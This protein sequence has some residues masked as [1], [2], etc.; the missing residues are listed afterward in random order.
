MEKK[1]SGNKTFGKGGV[2]D[3][4]VGALKRG[5]GRGGCDPLNNS[6]LLLGCPDS[7]TIDYIKLSQHDL[8]VSC[9]SLFLL[10][11]LLVLLIVLDQL[12]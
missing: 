4:G 6:A 10:L 9:P 1:E 2:L 7:W 5:M 12:I 8:S 11:P 3:K